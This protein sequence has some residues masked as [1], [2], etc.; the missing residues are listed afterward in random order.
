MYGKTIPNLK[1][2]VSDLRKL[3]YV[4]LNPQAAQIAADLSAFPARQAPSFSI[5]PKRLERES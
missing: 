2:L 3:P 1:W 4:R 5:A